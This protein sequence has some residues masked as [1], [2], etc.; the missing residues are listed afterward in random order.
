MANIKVNTTL[1]YM[2]S[3]PK[4]QEHI[5][6]FIEGKTSS[7]LATN[8]HSEGESYEYKVLAMNNPKNS[9]KNLDFYVSMKIMD[10]IT[11]FCHVYG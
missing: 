11:H 10:K 1:L 3:V 8:E 4:Q 6:I 7:S 5:K 9:I 2:A